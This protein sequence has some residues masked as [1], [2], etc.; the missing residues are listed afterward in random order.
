MQRKYQISILNS[1][2]ETVNAIELSDFLRNF[3]E[4]FSI[5]FAFVNF[6]YENIDFSILENNESMKEIHQ[7]FK[8]FLDNFDVR[9]IV[10][11]RKEFS[12]LEFSGIEKN[13]PLKFI[14]YCSAVSILALTLTV[15]LAGGHAKVAGC[16]FEVNSLIEAIAKIKHM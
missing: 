6:E 12:Q 2:R 9:F 11:G 16:E 10:H 3:Q 8:K 4:A 7:K 5:S 13:S 15:S 1:G 14:G